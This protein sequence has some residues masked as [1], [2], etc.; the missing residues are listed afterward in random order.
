[1][2]IQIESLF[3]KLME[4]LLDDDRIEDNPIEVLNENVQALVRK[5]LF[6]ACCFCLSD[7]TYG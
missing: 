4:Y 7:Y 6:Q 3:H 2:D 5:F 1:M